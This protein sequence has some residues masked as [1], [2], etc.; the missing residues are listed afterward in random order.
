MN[1]CILLAMANIRK[2]YYLHLKR[3]VTLMN[4]VWASIKH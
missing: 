1:L 4:N 3:D 2:C